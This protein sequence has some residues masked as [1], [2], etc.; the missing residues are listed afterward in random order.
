[1]WPATEVPELIAPT[2]E[3]LMVADKPWVIENVVGA[4]LRN[5]IKLCG[6]MF[7]LRVFR[8]RLFESNISLVQPPHPS[9]NGHRIGV[10]GFCCVCGHGDA[11]RGK[12][13]KVH[14]RL[15]TWQLAM[16]IDWMQKNEIVEAIP[17]AY[18]HYIG[19]QMMRRM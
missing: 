13:D 7:G 10:G 4:P 11:G 3:A 6:L 16:G 12:I 1:M 14:R 15:A 5:P 2:R 19:T 17:P 9:H 8:H 18:L